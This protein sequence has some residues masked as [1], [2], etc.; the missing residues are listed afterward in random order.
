MREKR[1]T[2]LASGFQGDSA[3]QLWTGSVR[4]GRSSER[5][6][7]TFRQQGLQAWGRLP[8]AECQEGV[9]GFGNVEVGG[10]SPQGLDG[11]SNG[12]EVR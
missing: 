4:H 12:L 5:R 2:R 8:R 10:K 6:E 11:M 7:A 3:R 9:S 1:K